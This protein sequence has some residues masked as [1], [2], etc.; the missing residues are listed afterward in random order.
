MR[1][2]AAFLEHPPGQAMYAALFFQ[3]KGDAKMGEITVTDDETTLRS[4]LTLLD[5]EGFPTTPDGTPT[6]SSSDERVCTVTA[7]DDGM[8]ATYGIGGPGD[9]T[10]TV[11]G[12]GTDKDGNEILGKGTVHVTPAGVAIVSVDFATG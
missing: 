5:A 8:T 11:T 2:I 7:A 9:A 3:T 4:T 12:L 6:Y 10:V 1:R